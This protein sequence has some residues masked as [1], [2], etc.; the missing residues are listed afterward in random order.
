MP[1]VSIT[2]LRVRVVPLFAGIFGRFAS[3]GGRGQKYN[4]V[5]RGIRVERCQSRIL[6][7]H[8]VG[9]RAIDARFHVRARAPPLDAEAF[10]MVR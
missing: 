6:V 9:R 1:L 4:R 7:A 8:A 5:S 3:R 2:R 10:A